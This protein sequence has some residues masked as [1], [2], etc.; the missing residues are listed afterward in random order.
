MYINI[1]YSSNKF[2]RYPGRITPKLLLCVLSLGISCRLQKCASIYCIAGRP[3]ICV[4]GS[5]VT[6]S[7]M[8]TDTFIWRPE[9]Y[10]K[11]IRW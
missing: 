4:W 7:P 11:A 6:R 9:I 2:K 3:N 5:K 1:S 8:A 10:D